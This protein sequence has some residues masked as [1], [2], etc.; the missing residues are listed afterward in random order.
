M[1][2]AI[3]PDSSFA[4]P[5]AQLAAQLGGPACPLMVDARKIPAFNQAGHCLPA[6]L[7]IAPED[8]DTAIASL[9]RARPIVVYC[10]HGH[11]V[12]QGVAGALR[13]AGLNARYLQGGV[14]AWEEAG[15]PTMTK[16]PDIGL[17]A[18]PGKPTAWVTR[19]RPKIDRIA[20]PWL[21]R[22]FI[23]PTAEF[24]YVPAADVA[25]TAMQENAIPYDVP[26]VQFSHRGL[27][28]ERCSFDA[29]LDDCGL[30]DP[31]LA[32]LA[33]I[34]RGADTGKP[35]LTPQSPGLL[36]ISL[37]LSVNYTGDHAML[38]Q[39]MVIYDA[40]YAWI[41]S[42]QAEVHNAKLFARK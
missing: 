29:F 42:A 10:L 34:V 31:C 38:E 27:Q 36:A 24:L 30:T 18:S 26:N 37:G 21:I 1:D 6:S 19:E 9:P 7:R 39:G 15:L 40:L 8:I 13:A 41:K 23:D 20:C 2:T 28:G 14:A 17:P 35:E 25:N 22:R 4:F 33:A 11:E 16:L 12:S 32:E 5:I 3:S